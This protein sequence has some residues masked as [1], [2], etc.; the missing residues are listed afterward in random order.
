MKKSRLDSEEPEASFVLFLLER[1]PLMTSS[2]KG[3]I[4]L[5]NPEIEYK[6][7]GKL[8]KVTK[9][10]IESPLGAGKEPIVG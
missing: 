7:K 3:K 9:I 10:L 1:K 2:A 5:V 4:I 8:Q 6:I